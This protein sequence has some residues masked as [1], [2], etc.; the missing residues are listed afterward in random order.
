MSEADLERHLQA[1]HV[2]RW[3]GRADRL[4]AEPMQLTRWHRV[5]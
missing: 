1:L 3:I 2:Q 5:K 4:L